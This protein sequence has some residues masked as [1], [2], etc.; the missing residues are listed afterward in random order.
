M[1]C[2]CGAVHTAPLRCWAS[3]RTPKLR[4]WSSHSASVPVPAA[5]QAH[6]PPF[7]V[8]GCV[9]S[10]VFTDVF[11][12]R[13][14]NSLSCFL[15]H[16]VC[17]TYMLGAVCWQPTCFY[18]F[19]GA[20]WALYV[21]NLQV[22]WGMLDR[23]WCMGVVC[24][25]PTCF[26]MGPVSNLQLVWGMLDPAWCILGAAGWQSTGLVAPSSGHLGAVCWQPT[27]LMGPVGPGLGHLGL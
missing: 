4:R 11:G 18:M 13:L 21:S 23:A 17:R 19:C 10:C 1:N 25:Q 15:T 6:R 27:G 5:G 14:L 3:P 7:N 8:L 12:I 22:F 9:C 2:A 16:T 20:C 26:Y 24:W